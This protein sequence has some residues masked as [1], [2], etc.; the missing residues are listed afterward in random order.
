M[1]S[2]CTRHCA[3]HAGNFRHVSDSSSNVSDSRTGGHRTSGQRTVAR[4]A[5]GL[6]K[7]RQL[8]VVRGMGQGRGD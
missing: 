7:G 6:Q 8:L 1:C 2:L 4:D 3:R 5:I